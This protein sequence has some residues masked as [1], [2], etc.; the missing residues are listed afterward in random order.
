MSRRP[1]YYRM[2]RTHSL[3]PVA[4][5]I[6]MKGT[7]VGSWG[8]PIERQLL[9]LTSATETSTSTILIVLSVLL[10]MIVVMVLVVVVVLDACVLIVLFALIV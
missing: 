2:Q 10:V 8:M 3:S 9:I 4:K 1:K 5:V 6:S 7:A